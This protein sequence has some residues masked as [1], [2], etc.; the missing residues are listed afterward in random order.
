MG[1]ITDDLSLDKT[2]FVIFLGKVLRSTSRVL[3]HLGSRSELRSS[4]YGFFDLKQLYHL[5]LWFFFLLG[6]LEGGTLIFLLFKPRRSATMRI[7][8]SD[9]LN[10]GVIV[11]SSL[12]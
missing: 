7:S 1:I 2:N 3:I 11:V 12:S 4:L 8:S 10:E 9:I 6:S 5:F